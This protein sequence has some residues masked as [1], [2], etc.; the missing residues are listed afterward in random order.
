LDG[1]RVM[2]EKHAST[3][4]YVW[5]LPGLRLRDKRVERLARK[6]RALMPWLEPSDFPAVRAWAE[7][8][9]LSNQ[10][11]AA[12]ASMG[13]LNRQGEARRLLSEYRQLRATQVML[14]R[15]LGMTPASR[16][17]IKATG[18]HVPFDLSPEMVVTVNEVGESRARDRAAKVRSDEEA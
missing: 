1:V 11:Y 8:E 5:A 9:Y 14:A 16:M 3:S 18:T 10:V 4:L 2:S 17:A 6:V 12:L 7:M 15:E 13:V